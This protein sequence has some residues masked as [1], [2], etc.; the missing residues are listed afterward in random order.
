MV[1]AQ[2]H[3]G[4]RAALPDFRSGVLRIFQ[5]TVPV[6]FLFVALLFGQHTGLEPQHTVRHHKACQ[7]A[8]GQ[9]IIAD[10]DLLI[11]K[12]VDD[13]LVDALVVAADQSQIVVFR[14]PP[15]MFFGVALTACR[16]EYNMRLGASL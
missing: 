14:Q 13:P 3:R 15:G 2:Q 11:G 1:A 6:A 7:L 16:Q 12:G 4:H 5:Q 8:A 9:D 10:G